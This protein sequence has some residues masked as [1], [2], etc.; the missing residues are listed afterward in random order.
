MN[1]R[2]LYL[3][4]NACFIAGRTIKIQ[5]IMVHSTGANNPNLRRYVGPDDGLLGHNP[6]NNHWNNFHPEG[7]VMGPHPWANNGNGRCVTCNGRQVCVHAFIGRLANGSIATYQTLPWD[8]RGWHGGGSVNDTHIGF[9][10]CEDGLTDR[11]YFNSVYQE[12]VELCA[13]LCKRFNFNPVADGVLIDHAEGHRKGIASNHAD[14]GHWFSRHGKNMDTFRN[15]VNELL[16][17]EKAPAVSTTPEQAEQTPGLELAPSFP[18]SDENLQAMVDMNIMSSPDY[19]RGITSIQWLNEL[20]SAVAA[21]VG[22]DNHNNRRA[23]SGEEAIE[24]LAD[25]GIISTPSYWNEVLKH[26]ILHFDSLLMNMAN[27]VCRL[28]Q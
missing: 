1:L 5:G 23:A 7:V 8:M 27:R 20:I 18:I 12:A 17:F 26:G 14:V 15:E 6:N 24:I 25:A 11:G 21:R 2:Q 22:C 3:R 10:I 28:P 13:Y 16:H 9:E 4:N 19:W